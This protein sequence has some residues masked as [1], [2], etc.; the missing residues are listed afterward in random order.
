MLP[1]P[2]PHSGA[3]NVAFIASH[4]GQRAAFITD[5]GSWTDELVVRRGCGHFGGSNYDERL[6]QRGLHL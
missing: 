5:L 4:Q 6:L 3:D 2:V 1:V